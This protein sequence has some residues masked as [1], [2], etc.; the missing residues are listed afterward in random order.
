M[1][2]KPLIGVSIL[3]VVLLVLG[4]LS[5]V[6]GYQSVKSSVNDSPL[7]RTRTQKA[8]NKEG[9]VLTSDYLGK[10]YHSLSFPLRDTN[11]DLI[12]RFVDNIRTM[13]DSAFKRFIS[14]AVNQIKYK[15][16]LKDI[17][18]K[19]FINGLDE[20]R[21]STQNIMVYTDANDD[22]ITWFNN[23]AP[24]I[25]WLP[26]C[27][28]FSVILFIYIFYYLSTNPTSVSIC[29]MECKLSAINHF[30]GQ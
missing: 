11:A 27:L 12:Q 3:A 8:I 15:D 17:N 28:F 20:L 4:S 14:N 21:E 25:C 29:P 1:D 26:G 7:F 23:F 16:S 5:N 13:D 9:N 6:V 10:G 19:E 2:E 24:T 22:R 30:L 18:I